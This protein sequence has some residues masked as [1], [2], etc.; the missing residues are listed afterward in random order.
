MLILKNFKLSSFIE[1]NPLPY[2]S[3]QQ[4]L[5]ILKNILR[6]LYHIFIVIN[7]ALGSYRARLHLG[8]NDHYVHYV[9]F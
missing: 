1:L 3:I 2:L 6:N 7:I 9:L 5:R 4:Q 8:C